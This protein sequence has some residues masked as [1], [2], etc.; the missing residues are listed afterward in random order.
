MMSDQWKTVTS[1]FTGSVKI[2][3]STSY[4]RDARARPISYQPR[5]PA[6]LKDRVRRRW[7]LSIKDSTEDV[8]VVGVLTQ[9]AAPFHCSKNRFTR[10][11]LSVDVQV[12]SVKVLVHPRGT[13]E[14][15]AHF[16]NAGTHGE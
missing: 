15:R 14:I 12:V 3:A 13:L 11:R 7:Q 10:C 2:N 6:A 9:R 5:T 16:L 4:S 1:V 8:D